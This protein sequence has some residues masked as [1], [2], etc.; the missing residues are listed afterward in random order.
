M[1]Q[2]LTVR[3]RKHRL[4]P[5]RLRPHQLLWLN[6]NFPGRP[7]RQHSPCH[8]PPS[9]PD[10]LC[11]ARPSP[12]PPPPAARQPPPTSGAKTPPTSP[13]TTPHL[14]A[15]RMAA[16][17][18]YDCVIT[19]SCNKATAGPAS[20][21]VLPPLPPH[22]GP[23]HRPD[24][25]RPSAFLVHI[26]RIRLPAPNLPVAPPPAAHPQ[27]PTSPTYPLHA[28]PTNERAPTT[29]SPLHQRHP[30]GRRHLLTVGAHPSSTH[31]PHP[32]KS[33]R[34]PPPPSL[35]SRPAALLP[36]PPTGGVGGR[37]PP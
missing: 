11:E 33:A 13:G 34:A 4:R 10:H 35:S 7:H 2:I 1:H 37:R 32:S 24:C 16:T 22:P 31:R 23:T 19:N 12:S 28:S 6:P 20:L 27:R 14:L 36:P 30:G 9:R 5:L 15:L 18:S 29:N 17:G 3:R 8:H 25:H 26:T 21:P